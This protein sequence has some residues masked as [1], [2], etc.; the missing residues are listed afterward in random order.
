MTGTEVREVDSS[1][2]VEAMVDALDFIPSVMTSRWQVS[3]QWRD[4]LL[5]DFNKCHRVLS[6]EPC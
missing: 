5:I 4:I 2:D 6:M 1:Q 3:E